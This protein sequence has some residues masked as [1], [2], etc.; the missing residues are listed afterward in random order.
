[1][2]AVVITQP[3]G[4]EVLKV[5]ERPDPELPPGHVR[6][7]VLYAGVN[8]ADLLQ[9]L[10]MYPAPPGVPTDIP[11]LEYMG[12]VAELGAGVTRF[13]VGD[14]VYGLLGGGGHATQVVV[15]EREAVPVPVNLENDVA[16]CIPE[17]F[18]TAYDALVVRARLKP[19][20]NT[21]VHAAGSGVG[22]AGIQLAR[23][24]GGLVLG[25]SR[26]REKLARC[27]ALGMHVGITVEKAKFAD[28]VRDATHGRGV[29]VVLELV[30]GEYL[31]EDFNVCANKG[32]I[33]LVGLTGGSHAEL[34]LRMMLTR[35]IEVI[36]TVLRARPLEEKIQAAQM[37]ERHINPWLADGKVKGVLDRVF[38]MEDVA[39]AHS[40]LASNESFGKVLL[41][42]A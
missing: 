37:L 30:G 2:R 28:R 22:T 33:V 10:G 27:S 1:M 25:T 21:L 41:K 13:R 6:V 39:Q 15:H 8:R 16:A 12:T 32:R 4:P 3:G 23:A 9:R 26:T 20:E 19:G 40:Y 11:G 42:M 14:R 38:P 31:Q 29:D 34:D 36:G 17:A 18:I 7:T 35:R 5:E 24:M